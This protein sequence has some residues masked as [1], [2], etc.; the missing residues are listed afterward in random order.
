MREGIHAGAAASPVPVMV[1][2]TLPELLDDTAAGRFADAGIA[3]IAGLRAGLAC[4]AALRQPAGDPTRVR[5]IAAAAALRANGQ[6]PWGEHKAKALLR[7]AGVPVVE[8][9]SPPARTRPPARWRTSD[10]HW[11]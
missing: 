6:T 10:R 3:A 2:S 7:R 8:G 11:C 1:T 5:A 4:A 9:R